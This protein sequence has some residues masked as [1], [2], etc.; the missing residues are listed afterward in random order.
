LPRKHAAQRG[1]I[2]GGQRGENRRKVDGRKSPFGQERD[3]TRSAQQAADLGRTKA[4]VDVDSQRA[5]P[6]VRKDRGQIVGAV[7]Q[8]QRDAGPG[9]DAGPAHCAR[10]APHAVAKSAP[11]QRGRCVGHRRR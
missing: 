11:G 4:R 1:A 10:C 8:S 3:R 7:G 5:K 2:V 6:P 9:A